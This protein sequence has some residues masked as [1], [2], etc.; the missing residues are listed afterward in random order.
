MSGKQ[1]LC[2]E[3]N[4][5]IGVYEPLIMML[6]GQIVETSRAGMDCTHSQHTASYHRS[7]FARDSDSDSDPDV[8]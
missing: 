3:C 8:R 5:V 1:L 4:E 2:H 7:C 6:D